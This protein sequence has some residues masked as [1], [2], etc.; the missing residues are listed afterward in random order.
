MGN[1][2]ITVFDLCLVEMIHLAIICINGNNA[3][4][5]YI[6]SGT[7]MLSKYSVLTN[8]RLVLLYRYTFQQVKGNSRGEY[9][10]IYQDTI[11]LQHQ[12]TKNHSIKIPA[13]QYT[14]IPTYQQIQHIKNINTP[15]NTTH[16]NTSTP[17]NQ[18]TNIRAQTHP[19]YEPESIKIKTVFYISL[20]VSQ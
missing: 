12:H 5:D 1:G 2:E 3:T 6:L 18:H 17:S 4:L 16:Q 15:T 13:H 8:P 20:Q 10:P 11:I 19:T 9:L 14:K 7:G